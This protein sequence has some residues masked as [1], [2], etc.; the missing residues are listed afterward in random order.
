M[1]LDAV[2]SPHT[3]TTTLHYLKRGAERR[4]RYV[5]EPR[6]AYRSGMA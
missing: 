1:P 2:V 3:V 6:R 4:A 5:A